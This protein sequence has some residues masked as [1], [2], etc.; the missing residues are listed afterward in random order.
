MKRYL[1]NRWRKKYTTKLLAKGY[2]YKNMR[3]T[4]DN[5][6]V[7]ISKFDIFKFNYVYRHDE[8]FKCLLIE[9]TI[10]NENVKAIESVDTSHST[11]KQRIN[12][13]KTL[14]YYQTIFADK[15]KKL[16]NYMN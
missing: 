10:A 6:L 7:F 13:N 9:S 14:V 3:N 4:I 2:V 1:L 16:L 15:Y 11:L 8:L 5:S 12:Y